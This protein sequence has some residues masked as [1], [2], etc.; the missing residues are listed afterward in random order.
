MRIPASGGDARVI[1]DETGCACVSGRGGHSRII[2]ERQAAVLREGGVEV[3]ELRVPRTVAGIK[4]GCVQIASRV[5][6][7]R[8]KETLAIRVVVDCHCWAKSLAT[9]GGLREFHLRT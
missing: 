5:R 3:V 2:G 7:Q 4:P 6:R 1:A 9:V 8:S